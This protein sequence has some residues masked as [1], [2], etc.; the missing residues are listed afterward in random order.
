MI[1]KNPTV[2]PMAI[3]FAVFLAHLV[4]LPVTGCSINPPRSFGPALIA[5]FGDQGGLFDDYWI[6]FV[7]PHVGG[8]VAGLVQRFIN[9][10]GECCP[11]KFREGFRPQRLEEDGDMQQDLPA[12]DV[13]IVEREQDL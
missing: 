5:G 10:G 2:A 6:F 7:A 1:Q 11:Q 9:D 4:L 8:F 12:E 13:E 3:G